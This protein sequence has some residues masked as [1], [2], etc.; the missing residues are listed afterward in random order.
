MG[1]LKRLSNKKKSRKRSRSPP[2]NS[3]KF[4]S[5]KKRARPVVN[6]FYYSEFDNNFVKPDDILNYK[7]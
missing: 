2:K 5:V 7:F 3:Y 1:R 6:T 4:Q